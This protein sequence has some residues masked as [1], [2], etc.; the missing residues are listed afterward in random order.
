MHNSINIYCHQDGTWTVI[1][2]RNKQFALIMKVKVTG[3]YD[4]GTATKY[5]VFHKGK[6]IASRV[7][8]FQEAKG[9]A[10]QAVS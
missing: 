7:D 5:Q 9:I 4:R 3:F 10:N 1:N 8:Y 6:I 2:N